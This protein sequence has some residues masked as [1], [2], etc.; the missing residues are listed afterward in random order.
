MEDNKKEYLGYGT[1]AGLLVG[2]LAGVVASLRDHFA[3]WGLG[4]AVGSLVGA[5]IGLVFGWTLYGIN[6][7]EP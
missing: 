5:V 7:K 3:L 1:L 4:L 6:K 2:A